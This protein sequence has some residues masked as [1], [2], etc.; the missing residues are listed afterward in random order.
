M[1]K[2][3]VPA[4]V[5]LENCT[6]SDCLKQVK[7]SNCQ[8]HNHTEPLTTEVWVCDVLPQE[9]K[10]IMKFIESYIKPLD[11]SDYTHIK[12][13]KKLT[14]NGVTY[15]TAVL[16]STHTVKDIVFVLDLL[17]SEF[18]ANFQTNHLRKQ[19]I[20][21]ELPPTKELAL[22]WS[23]KYW[24]L[25]WKGN[26]NHQELVR[27][28]F[29]IEDEHRIIAL[30]IEQAKSKKRIVTIIAR[31]HFEETGIEILK[32][33]YDESHKS[34]LLH[35]TMCAISA[36]AESEIAA[37][38]DAIG[39]SSQGY[40][41]HN[42][43]VYTTHEPC[44]MCAMALVHSRIGQLIYIWKHPL[45]AIETSHYIGDRNDLNWKFNIWR[46]VG[47]ESSQDFTWAAGVYP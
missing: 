7:R 22:R 37:R 34:I 21:D 26:P 19:E 18:D 2:L 43:L 27:A 40:L 42:L 4:N 47:P 23:D 25:S 28:R 13:F 29:N 30:L 17:R 45:G 14:I 20:P 9:T 5:D 32:I 15:I 46:W 3:K 8:D 31:K 12:R 36:M 11:F 24:P 35:S 16:C 39:G 38:H 44:T 10:A 33:A 1:G 41:C 6:I